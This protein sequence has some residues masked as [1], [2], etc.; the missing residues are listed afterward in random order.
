LALAHTHLHAIAFLQ[1]SGETFSIPE[2]GVHLDH[3]RRLPHPTA[4]F[5]QLLGRESGGTSGMVS[6]GQTGQALEVK[7]PHPIDQGAGR[8]PKESGRLLATHTRSDEQDAVQSV[9]IS[10]VLVAVNLW[11][12]HSS[13]VLR[14]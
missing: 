12:Q 13:A 5:L 10:G 4:H 11:L 9:I 1:T 3:R 2:S 7:T 14:R 6:F 8:V